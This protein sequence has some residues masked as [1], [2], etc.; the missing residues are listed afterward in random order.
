MLVGN[1]EGKRSLERTRHR[2]VNDTERN[3]LEVVF[4]GLIWLR[5]GTSGGLASMVTNLQA[6]YNVGKSFSMSSCME[7][8]GWWEWSAGESLFS[9]NGI[10]CQCYCPHSWWNCKMT[11]VTGDWTFFSLLDRAEWLQYLD[12]TLARAVPLAIRSHII[13]LKCMASH[14]SIYIVFKRPVLDF[15]QFYRRSHCVVEILSIII[16][17]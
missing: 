9:E 4:S 6:P 2:L 15:W 3:L 12:W 14:I 13:L 11:F 10:W 8:A 1:T 16:A 7:L 17:T 5:M